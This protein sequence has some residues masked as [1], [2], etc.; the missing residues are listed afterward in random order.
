MHNDS[1]GCMNPT[2][3]FN[4]PDATPVRQNIHYAAAGSTN[5]M[6]KLDGGSFLMGT[7]YEEGWPDDG[8]GPVREVVINPFWISETQV[9]NQQFS[10]FIDATSYRTEAER[11]GWSFVFHLLLP[12]RTRQKLMRDRVVGIEWWCKVDHAWWRMPEG[13]GSNIKRR[14]DHPVTHISWSDAIA[15]CEWAEKRLPTEAEW[16]YAARGGHEQRIFPWGD[17]LEPD[18]KHMANVFQGNF[19]FHDTGADGYKGTCPVKAFPANDFEIYGVIGNVWEWNH[20]WFHPSHHIE[21]S[22]DNPKGPEQGENKLMKGGSF[23]CHDS[24]CNRYRIGA[25]TSNSADSS[26]SNIGF[27]CV[28]DI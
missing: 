17:D 6:I 20:D 5:G 21:A 23:L 25:R 15:Y 9:T 2:P 26:T 24:Y 8:E 27:R 13:R 1:D 16:E 22:K 3:N 12:P 14:M 7:D 4:N 10:Q 19:P 11:Y 28:R 18:G